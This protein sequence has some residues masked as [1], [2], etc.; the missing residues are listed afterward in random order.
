MFWYFKNATALLWGLHD[1]TL[2]GCKSEAITIKMKSTQ[3]IETI[4][5]L[6][7][8]TEARS[9]CASK[10]APVRSIKSFGDTDGLLG[11]N[12]YRFVDRLFYDSMT[13]L[14]PLLLCCFKNGPTPASCI[15]YFQPFQT[16]SITVLQQI[17]VEN[18]HPVYGA[19]IRTHDLGNMSLLP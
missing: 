6:K 18:V 12:N 8:D 17:Y 4:M 1:L 2:F 7:G 3:K 16:N 13:Q 5:S 10:E 15:I 14:S 9:F 19:R 11:K